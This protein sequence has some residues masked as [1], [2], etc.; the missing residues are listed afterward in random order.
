MKS[1]RYSEVSEI[2]QGHIASTFKAWDLYL[3][4][5]VLIKKLSAQAS[6][7]AEYLEAFLWEGRVLCQL[8]HPNLVNFFSFEEGEEIFMAMEYIEGVKLSKLID[9]Q[10]PVFLTFDIAYQI[11]SGLSWL[12]DKQLVHRDLSLANILFSD[13]QRVTIIDFGLSAIDNYS[14]QGKVSDIVGTP[15][16]LSPEQVGGDRGDQKSD[17][18]SFGAILYEMLTAQKPFQGNDTETIFQSICHDT[19]TPISNFNPWATEGLI[20]I[21]NLCLE[22]NPENRPT[23]TFLLD[24]IRLLP[25]MIKQ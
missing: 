15:H 17:I 24:K 21:V 23:A 22:K 13:T 7:S 16:Y 12:H 3:Q 1:E 8:N 19:P 5:W 14:F 4:R 20:E 10:L 18:F 6:N 2:H 25:S 11:L 9:N